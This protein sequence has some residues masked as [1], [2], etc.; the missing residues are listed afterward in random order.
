MFCV[1]QRGKTNMFFISYNTSIGKCL[2]FPFN[3][4]I[5]ILYNC[6]FWLKDIFTIFLNL[7]YNL[8]LVNVSSCNA[9]FIFQNPKMNREK[10]IHW[11]LMVTTKTHLNVENIR[12]RYYNLID[13]TYNFC[14][15]CSAFFGK[16]V[17]CK[18]C[19]D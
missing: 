15:V 11:D 7:L 12:L 4:S 5:A 16:M 6:D 19:L 13:A 14:I 8:L 9:A 3:A 17:F 18:E 10:S 1:N 2:N